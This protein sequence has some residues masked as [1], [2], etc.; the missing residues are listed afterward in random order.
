MQLKDSRYDS[1]HAEYLIKK[2]YARLGWKEN[3]K[4]CP[5]RVTKLNINY[6]L[7]DTYP[8]LL[9]VPQNAKDNLIK[10]AAQHR[11]RN[12]LPVITWSN[13]YNISLARSSQPQSGANQ[14]RNEYDERLLLLLNEMNTYSETFVICDCRPRVN[15]IANQ[16]LKGKGF[17]AGDN[18]EKAHI[19][20]FDIQNIHKMRESVNALKKCCEDQFDSNWL[21]NLHETQWFQHITKII[22]CSRRCANMI[23]KDRYSV[24]VH[25][26]DG[27]DRTA[28]V[29]SLAQLLLDPYYRTFHG[30]LLLIQK[31]WLWFGHKFSDRNANYNGVH[32]NNNNN[33]NKKHHHT[34]SKERSPIFLQFLDCC[35][36]VMMQ[37]PWAFEFTQDLLLEFSLHCNSGRFG[38]FFCNCHRERDKQE[39]WLKTPSLFKYL[40]ALWQLGRFRNPDYIPTKTVLRPRY[41]VRDMILWDEV[42]C[43]FTMH[44]KDRHS[45]SLFLQKENNNN[46]NH[47]HTNNKP[48][49]SDTTTTITTTTTN[50]TPRSHNPSISQSGKNRYHP[51]SPRISNMFNNNNNNN[52]D[53]N[54]KI[55]SPLQQPIGGGSATGI[56]YN[57]EY[58]DDN[59]HKTPLSM[60]KRNK[61]QPPPRKINNNN[62]NNNNKTAQLP[63]S[64]T[65]VIDQTG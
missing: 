2:E 32:N 44:D 52:K 3:D 34:S 59:E 35:F 56:Q 20:F 53:K 17:E 64:D 9:L 24:L 21:K 7:C 55:P 5:F 14:R 29:C 61:P 16:Y 37:F 13:S 47:N 15:A 54:V 45:S 11:S 18:Y 58:D 41:A 28:Q 19:I 40:S 60:S 4:N 50:Y 12:R 8:T 49:I 36:Q 62:Y 10:R 6:E 39:L 46:N 25:C 51:R 33:N 30:F 57:S 63:P 26:S 23:D 22:Q 65:S 27:W 48:S 31:E 43:R 42:Y 1:S 38:D